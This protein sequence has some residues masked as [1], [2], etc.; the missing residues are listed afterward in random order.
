MDDEKGPQEETPENVAKGEL[1]YCGGTSW[2][3]MGR[4]TSAPAGMNLVSPTRLRPLIGVDIRFVASGCSEFPLF[5]IVSG[6][7]F[8]VGG[9]FVWMI[10]VDLFLFL[11]G[12][13]D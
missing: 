12:E 9:F 10:V 4:K 3:S 13:M 7:I 1:L 8:F 2:D 11:F 5:F 6:C